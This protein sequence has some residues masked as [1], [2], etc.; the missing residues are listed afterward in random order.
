LSAKYGGKAVLGFTNLI[1]SFLTIITP[2]CA[3]RSYITLAFCR[4]FIGVAH[5]GNFIFNK[6]L[7]NLF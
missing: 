4:F 1:A 7:L 2:F 6:S 5:V 3:G